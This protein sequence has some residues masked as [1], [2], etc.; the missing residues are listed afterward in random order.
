MRI[1]IAAVSSNRCMSGVSRHATNLAKCMLGRSEITALHVL[2]APWEEGYLRE[3]I[4]RGDQRLSIHPVSL[5][6]GTLQRNAW[7]YRTLP[8]IA[9]QLRADLVH[10][11]YPSLLKA[12]AFSCPTVVT[13]HDLYPYD[14]PSNFGFPKVVFNRMALGQCLRNASA[15]A[16]VSDSTRLRLGLRMPQMLPKAVTIYNCAENGPT[17]RKPSFAATWKDQ[18]FLLCVAQHRRNK[19]VLFALR[20]FKRALKSGQIAS[21]MRLV[22]V[23]LPGPES[24]RIDHFVK[25]EGLAESVTFIDGILDA[26]LNWCYRNCELLL[27]PSTI[28]GFGL[29]VV[30]AQL[31]GCRVV[32]SDIPAF[33]EVGS[34]GCKFVPLTGDAEENFVSEVAATLRLPRPLPVCLPHLSTSSVAQE[35]LRLYRRVLL[36]S[37]SVTAAERAIEKDVHAQSVRAHK[38]PTAAQL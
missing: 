33:R 20:V 8:A 29:P 14:I 1:V 24:G 21:N 17:P 36:P 6:P 11:A 19:N 37:G 5:R 30:E 25:R 34:V 2:V 12:N 27:A 31:A 28:E 22:V 35:Y 16:C 26:E 7:Y 38:V 32:C 18:Q 23:G 4:S 3:A 13:L 9:G 10:L 15:I